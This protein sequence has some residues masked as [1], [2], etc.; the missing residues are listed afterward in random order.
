MG[1]ILMGDVG[2]IVVNNIREIR[3]FKEKFP[4]YNGF[5]E[6]EHGGSPFQI[7][8]KPHYFGYPQNPLQLMRF[9]VF[10]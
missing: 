2:D 9:F 10:F 1:N 5:W 3:R 6:G 4:D 7:R 8:E